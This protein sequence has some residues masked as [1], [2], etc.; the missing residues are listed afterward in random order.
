MKQI[1]L[2]R[3]E[4][5][6]SL[7]VSNINNPR[8]PFLYWSCKLPTDFVVPY[9]KIKEKSLEVGGLIRYALI[10]SRLTYS[11]TLRDATSVERSLFFQ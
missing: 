8:P 3:K 4:H 10:R 1:C 5:K 7:I 6:M 11:W 2:S 9:F